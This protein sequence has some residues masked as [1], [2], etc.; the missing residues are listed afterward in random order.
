MVRSN[1]ITI[2]ALGLTW[3]N[4]AMGQESRL[5]AVAQPATQPGAQA[6]SGE[7]TMTVQEMGKPPRKCRVLQEW[8][9]GNGSTAYKVQANDNGEFMTIAENSSV[10]PTESIPVPVSGSA[11]P[12]VLKTMSTRIYHWGTSTTS[13][14]GAP[15]PPATTATVSSASCSSGGNQTCNCQDTSSGTRPLFPRL[16][17]ALTGRESPYLTVS[18]EQMILPEQMTQAKAAPAAPAAA[19]P[20]PVIQ[21]VA[22]RTVVN[23]DDWR[24]SWGQPAEYK[25]QPTAKA[26]DKTSPKKTETAILPPS[27]VTETQNRPDPLVSPEKVARHVE[28]KLTASKSSD[29]HLFDD[30]PPPPPP[31]ESPVVSSAVPVSPAS[32]PQTFT[33]KMPMGAKS[34]LAAGGG[35]SSVTYLP[36]PIVTV[37]L[38]PPPVPP[39]PPAPTLPAPPPSPMYAN[40][41]TPAPGPMGSPY[42][43]GMAQQSPLPADP[44]PY[45][46]AGYM[47]T[48]Y[49]PGPTPVP[50][51]YMPGQNDGLS[52]YYAMGQTTGSPYPGRTPPAAQPQQRPPVIYQGPTAPNPFASTPVTPVVYT[53]PATPT[54]TVNAAMDRRI[55]TMAPAQS[56]GEDTIRQLATTLRI[57]IYPSQREIAAEDLTK[58]DCH[59]HPE[60]LQALLLA[61]REDAAPLVRATCV[62]CLVKM[63]AHGDQV[64]GTLA[65]LRSDKDVHVRQEVEQ[66]LVALK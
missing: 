10:V 12:M 16:R 44:S 5:Q 28:E 19:A 55:V 4:G 36:V 18:G 31:P 65:M 39:A 15:V 52:P 53:P 64:L 42:V 23:A 6:G 26:E 47:P 33:P 51:P 50:N 45:Q 2:L 48:A 41:F 63:K 27:S 61:A 17:Q 35:P 66:A 22:D 37:P 60:V 62:H 14:A 13:P 21:P 59:Q 38:T 40:A 29:A 24:K 34:V 20:K 1:W 11:K 9:Q 56:S 57:S 25:I 7:R 54:V 49:V 8:R 32:V 46:Q 58:Y 43:P 30:L 3:A